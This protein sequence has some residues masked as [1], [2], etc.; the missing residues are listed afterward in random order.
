M[1]TDTKMAP[2]REIDEVLGQTEFGEWISKNKTATVSLVGLLI[3]GIFGWGGYQ[4]VQNK[5]EQELN[6]KIYTFQEGAYTQ[7][8]DK[9][10]APAEF[11]TQFNSLQSEVGDFDGLAPVMIKASGH[12]VDQGAY[13]EAIDVLDLGYGK[14][15]PVLNN[16]IA[17]HLAA[18]LED[19][20]DYGRAI[21]I[22]EDL[23]TSSMKYFEDKIYLDLG[24][25]YL[26]SG[27]VEKAKLNLQYLIDN[28]KE[29]EFIKLARL[30][31]EDIEQ[32]N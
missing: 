23:N 17:L 3:L 25:L 24:R 15:G 28:G 8:I 10:L 7:L 30:H 12:L 31:L 16:L 27:N 2:N 1:A 21:T 14:Y 5:K 11:V 9:K 32:G 6:N 19:Q 22:L 13:K 20:K 4:S 26:T 29:A 18:A